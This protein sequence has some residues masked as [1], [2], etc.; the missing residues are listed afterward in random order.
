MAKVMGYHFHDQVT[1]DYD[2]HLVPL[3]SMFA[4]KKNEV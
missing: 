2:F 3:P 1:N 4:L